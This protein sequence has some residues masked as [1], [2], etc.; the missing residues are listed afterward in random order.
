MATEAAV[1][2]AERVV[3]AV[4]AA[5]MASLT[6]IRSVVVALA[7]IARTQCARSQ[8]ELRACACVNGGRRGDG[9]PACLRRE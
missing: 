5:E 8:S 3:T 2:T 7:A 9:S 6:C 4:T 1:G